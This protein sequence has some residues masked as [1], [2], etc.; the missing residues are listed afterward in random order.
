MVDGR[1]SETIPMDDYI[2]ANRA[3][4]NTWADFHVDST[5]YDVEGFKAGR[6]SL[7][8]TEIEEVGDVAGKSLL[9]LQCHFGMDTRSRA[10]RGATVTGV[11]FSD[12]AIAYARALAEEAGIP[13]RFVQS[14]LYSRPN[15]LDGEFDVVFTSY[16]VL[17]WLPDIE[18]WA[19]V[20]ARFL[21][22]GGRFAIVEYHPFAAVFESEGVTSLEPTYSYFHGPEP[23]RFET[24]GSYAGPTPGYQGVEYGWQHSLSEIVNALIAAGLRL[25]SLRE[26][27][28]SNEQRFPFMERAADGRWRL[29]GTL[30][31]M[32][33]LL[34]SL[35]ATK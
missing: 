27:P 32:I 35:R 31:G 3:L 13:A 20:V 23:L 9:H 34:F 24:S 14:D 18:R 6:S 7:H 16:G 28:Y 1:D 2:T 15:V 26:F 29:P 10:R 33:P 5:F 17:Y 12:H 19:T 25:E 11:D 30:D 22:P 8:S 4:W 21:K